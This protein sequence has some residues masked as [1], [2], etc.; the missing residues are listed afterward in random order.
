MRFISGSGAIHVSL[1][2]TFN[3]RIDATSGNGTL[4]SEF[5]ISVVGRFNAQHIR[6]TIGRGGPLIRIST[7]NGPIELKKN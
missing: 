3:G 4:R 7:G 1:P 6:G 2:E 5:E